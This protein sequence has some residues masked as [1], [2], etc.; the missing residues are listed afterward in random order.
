MKKNLLLL[1]AAIV[2]AWS[3]AAA[4]GEM[5][6][7]MKG[8]ATILGGNAHLSKAAGDTIQLMGPTGSGAAYLGDFEAGWNG[9]TT[10]DLTRTT[11]SHWQVSDFGLA[12]G[13]RAAWCGDTAFASCDD[14]L[15]ASGGYG[16]NWHD[17]LVFRR[18]VAD[19]Q[20][21]ASVQ[22]TASLQWDSEPGFDYVYLSTKTNGQIG[23]TN[24]RSWDGA[25]S[26]SVSEFMSFDPAELIDGTDVYVLFRFQSD[27]GWDDEDCSWPTS[28]ACRVDDVVVTISQGGQAD[29]VSSTDFQDGT[30][31]DWVIAYPD[32]VGDFAQIWS[33]LEDIDPCRTNYSNQIAFI[34]DNIVVPGTGGGTCVNWCYG[35]AGY[36]VNTV[37]GL[38][39]PAF[40]VQNF[41]DS[42]IMAWPNASYDGVLLEFDVFRHEDLSVD[43][44]GVFYMF[45]VRSGTS[46]AATGDA[47]WLDRNGVY[48][49]DGDYF[50]EFFPV[51]DLM[52]PGRTHVQV[53]LGVWEAGWIWGWIGND[54]Y[55]AP[56]FDNV[57]LKIYP[58]SGPGMSTNELR[59]ANDAFPEVDAINLTD[60]GSLHVRFD[61]AQNISPSTHL[62]NDPGDSTVIDIVPV[63]TGATLAGPPMLHYVIDANP[64]FDPYRTSPVSGAVPG[65]PADPGTGIPD[66]AK[67]A[68]DLPDTG[69][70]F[71]GDVLH[72]YVR[73]GDDVGGDVQYSTLPANLAGFG[74][75]S[76][77]LAYSSSFT[78]HA[79]PSIRDD[80]FGGFDVPGI[81]FWNDFANRGG[82]DEWYGALS[83]LGFRA[84]VDYDIYYTNRPDSGVG[85]GIG[86]R[87]SGLALEFYDDMLYTSGDMAVATISNGDYN[88]DAG[89]DIGALLNWMSDGNKD[90]FL[91]GDSLVGDLAINAGAAGG[92]FSED[93]MGVNLLATDVRSFINGQTTP[94][95]RA[96]PGN[97]VIQTVD[98]WIAY[99]GCLQINT[100]DGV[101][102]RAGA[103][104]LAEFTDQN[105]NPGAYSFA[106][107]TLNVYN[108]TNRI[109]SM[110]Y[111]LRYLY[112]DTS[113]KDA[114]PL[115]ARARIL[116]E[117]LSFFGRDG[118]PGAVTGVVPEARFEV[119]N[120]PNPFNPSTQIAYSIKAPGRLTLKVFDVRG[121]LVKTLIDGH[122]EESS[123]IL[124]DGT[125]AS[126]AKV[127]S[128]VYFTEARMG[129]DV[130]VG[131]MALVK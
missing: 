3:C 8:D 48:F 66:D 27:G 9:W 63:R 102:A 95:V 96:V 38:A 4:A 69:L 128:G 46:A 12:P 47:T 24:I 115:A 131:K 28:G 20:A 93:V 55:P 91:T 105:G 35:P 90:L 120:Y 126:G 56:Y 32:G 113:A 84:G 129:G 121:Q 15:D 123:H 53:Q 41:V 16:H 89:N 31:G 51:T 18:A 87:T 64:L 94:L 124:W 127:A 59:I 17:L 122:V 40:H 73:A 75:F 13:E 37:G 34:D 45:G 7:F 106:A 2:L 110:P 101:V 67:W 70:L 72:Y 26:E 80:G 50:R 6:R 114:A 77:P 83:N 44:P 29:I 68:F 25:G 97:P 111:D 30:F 104:R 85:N 100:F 60:L 79:L 1:T 21:A 92:A 52:T 108:G 43:A 22:L 62:R 103:Q 5:P 119:S 125:D 116:G 19:P 14:S 65:A 112:T 98:S 117:V 10:E 107:A 54:G 33:G 23:Y 82:E 109:V 118:D 49:G 78:V 36:I 58:F 86:G 88:V 76:H 39:G 130:Q 11:I 81:L 57:S 74:D 99:G 61:A 71:P 42:P